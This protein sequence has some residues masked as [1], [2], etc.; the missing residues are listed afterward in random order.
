MATGSGKTFIMAGLILYLYQKG[1]RNF[2]F[3]VPLSNIKSKTID[4]FTVPSSQKYLFAKDI[5]ID[6]EFVKIRT[7]NSF[8]D[9]SPDCINICFTTIQQIHHDYWDVRENGITFEEMTEKK[10]V[11]I[12]DEAHHLNADTAKNRAE[13]EESRS[14]EYVAKRL[15][16]ANPNNFMLEFT[17]TCRLDNPQ[18][19]QEYENKIVYDYDLKHFRHDRYSK[20]VKTF[21]SDL[22]YPDMCLQAMVLS[23][24]RL[25]LFNDLKQD[26]K[27]VILFKSAKKNDSDDF[28][29]Q[30]DRMM[31]NLDGDRLTRIRDLESPIIQSAFSYFENKGIS[32]DLLARELQEG[33]GV[34]RRIQVKDD[35][36]IKSNDRMLNSLE[37]PDNPVRA[38][39][40]VKA[41]D[42]GWDV[43]NLFDIVRL[44]DTRDAK[45]G[46]PG[47]TTVSE[48]QLIGRGARYCPF[49]IDNEDDRYRRKFDDD[50]E[51]PYR[52]CEEMYYHCHTN[53][54]YIDE[55]HKALIDTGMMDV[56]VLIRELHLKE[57]FKQSRLYRSGSVLVNDQI[58][59]AY[60]TST[61]LPPKVRSR[62]H[63]YTVPGKSAT[64]SQIMLGTNPLG[65]VSEPVMFSYTVKQ[66]AE[67]NY[68]T[69]HSAI[70]RFPRFKLSGL[71]KIYPSIKSM[72][73]FIT[74]DD[75][76][77]DIHIDILSN[78]G[79]PTQ[80]NLFKACLK[81]AEEIATSLSDIDKQYAGSTEFKL[82]PFKDIFRDKVINYQDTDAEIGRPQSESVNWRLDLSDK[83]WYVFNENYGTGEEKGFVKHF[84]Q[85][86]KPLLEKYDN[87]YL[88]RNERHM[89]IYSFDGG[90]RF[91][92]DF[93][94]FLI[95]C[96]EPINQLQV[97]IEP[98]GANLFEKDRWKQDFLLELADK[99]N[100]DP[101]SI[102]DNSEYRLEGM[103]FYNNS[104]HINFDEAFKEL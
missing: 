52:V 68:N 27:P 19:R 94:L 101:T 55:L 70:R 40:E 9:A 92:P 74:S 75:F 11:F 98:K 93:L 61:S 63:H 73:Q 53:S 17:A 46:I 65:P 71:Q 28:L 57:S 3:F 87:V 91:E 24:Y 5:L 21:Q 59:M 10:I 35:S 30:F 42:E 31:E 36:A 103:P 45:N 64:I 26:I 72:R 7:V 85:K 16:K 79:V 12:S 50:L 88:V 4:N 2:L 66:I 104:D 29:S 82:V 15:F 41:L 20:E 90:S 83:E 80:E 38:I 48:A 49:V 13:E 102:I 32:L 18:I 69:V 34:S 100:I 37:E 62:T 25:H 43:L 81:M 95:N 67:M 96:G 76:L 23:Q 99:W 14:W 54:R 77:G 39:F 8:Q 89:H 97:F 84:Y 22:D 56:K 6:G 47:K 58:E 1:Y 78:S 86:M 60:G 51:N 44:Y 33:F